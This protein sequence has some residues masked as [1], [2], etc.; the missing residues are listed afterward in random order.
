MMYDKVGLVCRNELKI[1][2]PIGGI[3]NKASPIWDVTIEL[4]LTKVKLE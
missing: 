4:D 3:S 2:N 1:I